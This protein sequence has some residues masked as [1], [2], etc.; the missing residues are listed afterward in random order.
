M[1]NK[2]VSDMQTRRDRTMEFRRSLGGAIS[3]NGWTQA[4]L[5]SS[6][7][8][9]QPTIGNWLRGRSVPDANS[10]FAV[11]R[12]LSLIPGE[13]SVHLG[14]VPVNRGSLISELACHLLQS[15]EGRSL[16]AVEKSAGKASQAV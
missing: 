4:K 14:Y 9:S 6:I 16:L 10:V 5:A 8:V 15:D 1:N 12:A 13:L 7:G 2:E 3:R 11:E